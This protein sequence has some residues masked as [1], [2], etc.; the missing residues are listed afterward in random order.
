[1]PTRRDNISPPPQLPLEI[2]GNRVSGG[3]APKQKHCVHAHT[4]DGPHGRR[5]FFGGLG[6]GTQLISKALTDADDVGTTRR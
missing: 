2:H 1:M 4:G 3:T 5:S 6:T